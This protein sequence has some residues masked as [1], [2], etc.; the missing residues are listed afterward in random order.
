[1]LKKLERYADNL[2]LIV[3]RRTAELE[4][5]KQKT[6]MLLY[7]MLPPSVLRANR[8]FHEVR[9]TVAYRQEKAKNCGSKAADVLANFLAR[10]L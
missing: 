10:K 1:M 5:E 4:D 3:S 7:R 9:P 8:P 2:E 6:D